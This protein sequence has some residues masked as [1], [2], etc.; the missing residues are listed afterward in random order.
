VPATRFCREHA[1]SEED[2]ET[3]DGWEISQELGDVTE[4]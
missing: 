3:D 4:E 1:G 2:V